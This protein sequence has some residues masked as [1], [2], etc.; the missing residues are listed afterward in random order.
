MCLICFFLLNCVHRKKNSKQ[1]DSRVEL[2]AVKTNCDLT[3]SVAGDR[4][5][6]KSA[7][8][9]TTSSKPESDRESS[10]NRFVKDMRVKL[11]TSFIPVQ[12]C[13]YKCAK[14]DWFN[15]GMNLLNIEAI[16][17]NLTDLV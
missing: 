7:Q 12:L 5:N 15:S 4:D 1:S 17:S 11:P 8:Q 14:A 2:D 6:L 13:T 10:T 9:D 3:F 16:R